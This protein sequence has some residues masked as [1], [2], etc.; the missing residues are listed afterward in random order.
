MSADAI[1]FVATD[2]LAPDDVHTLL[3]LPITVRRLCFTAPSVVPLLKTLFG[4][5]SAVSRE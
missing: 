4:S 2:G 1:V 3:S 5:D